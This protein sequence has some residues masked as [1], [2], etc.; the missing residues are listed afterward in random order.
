MLNKNYMVDSF[1]KP[2]FGKYLRKGV[3]AQPITSAK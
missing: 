1:A 2:K 3:A